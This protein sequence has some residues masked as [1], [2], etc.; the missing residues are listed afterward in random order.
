MLFPVLSPRPAEVIDV[1]RIAE[2]KL[3]GASVGS[4]HDGAL[5]AAFDEF[6]SS[7]RVEAGKLIPLRLHLQRL[8]EGFGIIESLLDQKSVSVRPEYFDGLKF[9]TEL[10]QRV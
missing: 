2:D 9:I 1:A 5:D 3:R 7:R 6:V 10:E 4:V 8:F